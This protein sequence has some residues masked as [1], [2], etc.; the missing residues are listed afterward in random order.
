MLLEIQVDEDG[1]GAIDFAEFVEFMCNLKK[2]ND[3]SAG[4]K[5]SSPETKAR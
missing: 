1:S 5:E 4:E 2:Y 3:V